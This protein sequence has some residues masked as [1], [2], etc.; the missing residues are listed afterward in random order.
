M[1][2]SKNQG[3][4]FPIKRLTVN[5]APADLLKQSP[6]Y[7]LPMAVGILWASEQVSP[8]SSSVFIGELSLDGSVRHADGI[9]PMVSVAKE[10]GFQ[11]VFAPLSDAPEA[12]LIGG[13]E[14]I[15]L[16]S[17]SQLVAHL[18]GSEEIPVYV[19]DPE[20]LAPRHLNT[21]SIS[22]IYEDRSM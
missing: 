11:R 3:F 17:L 1:T 20:V 15:P 4:A 22:L 10:E 5:L 21:L 7:D 12:S 19:A 6:A 2:V 18:N 14:I 8:L 13:L 9:L 16:E